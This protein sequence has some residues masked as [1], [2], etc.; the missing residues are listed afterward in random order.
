MGFAPITS[1]ERLKILEE[2]LRQDKDAP[3]GAVAGY[4]LIVLLVIVLG[5]VFWHIWPAAWFVI[6]VMFS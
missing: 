6:K 4:L 3:S 1:K 5:W 2:C